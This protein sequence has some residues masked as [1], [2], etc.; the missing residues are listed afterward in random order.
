MK[1]ISDYISFD[2]NTPPEM[3]IES[4]GISKIVKIE[5]NRI[6]ND[7]DKI[8]FTKE[9]KILDNKVL[10]DINYHKSDTIYGLSY[11]NMIS[12][13]VPFG[14]NDLEL[15]KVLTHELNHIYEMIKRIENNVM[16]GLEYKLT[17]NNM[18]LRNRY[19]DSFIQEL[20]YMMYIGSK[21]EMGSR[22]TETYPILMNLKTNNSDDLYNELIKTSAWKYSEDL[23]NFN[24]DN[25]DINY[26]NLID[27]LNDI[28]KNFKDID[29]KI[30]KTPSNEKD[31]NIILNKWVK[32][33]KK[34]HEIFK[35]KLIR[36]ISEV[37]KDYNDI[38]G[39]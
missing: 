16:S 32:L 1:H 2:Y 8:P 26:D 28:N 4:L 17:K 23:N 12:I 38:N 33:F 10:I 36:M 35:R 37:I 11:P 3:I 25:Y 14:Y 5:S 13:K 34:K 20:I 31:C 9:Y 30:F 21:H 19:N 29:F 27:Y 7:I 22:V 39:L 18:I 24:P 6:F 15:Q